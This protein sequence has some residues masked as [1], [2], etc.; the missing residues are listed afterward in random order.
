MQ[1]EEFKAAKD[2][3]AREAK[4]QEKKLSKKRK[5]EAE[6]N[7]VAKL[8]RLCKINQE[9]I[10]TNLPINKKFDL[11]DACDSTTVEKL[12]SDEPNSQ[13]SVTKRTT[14]PPLNQKDDE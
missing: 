6:I 8:K 9:E 5:K 1:T 11:V 3:E 7:A 14:I 13:T 12:I 4:K 2:N 10:G